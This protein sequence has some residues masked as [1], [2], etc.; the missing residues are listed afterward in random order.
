MSSLGPNPVKRSSRLA[1]DNT[2]SIIMPIGKVGNKM[3]PKEQD[4]FIF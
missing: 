2:I 3:L 4:R 1:S